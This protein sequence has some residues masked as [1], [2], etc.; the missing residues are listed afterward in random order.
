MTTSMPYAYIM[1]CRVYIVNCIS[2]N[3]TCKYS[4]T[5]F[6]YSWLTE[7]NNCESKLYTSL[8]TG[9]QDEGQKCMLITYNNTVS[10]KFS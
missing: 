1:M 3:V 9:T 4:Y 8:S 7:R 5:L 6:N 2:Y 10:H